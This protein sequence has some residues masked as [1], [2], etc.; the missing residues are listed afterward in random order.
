MDWNQIAELVLLGTKLHFPQF[1]V[2]KMAYPV[3]IDPENACKE[4]FHLTG[5]FAGMV[6]LA[7]TLAAYN[8]S[9]K[10]NKNAAVITLCVTLGPMP[11]NVSV[12]IRSVPPFF[13]CD[14]GKA[15]T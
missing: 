5:S 2:L 3:F 11:A 13:H 12:S 8:A 9:L 15:D 4:L 1:M 10:A 14:R 7:L 6:F